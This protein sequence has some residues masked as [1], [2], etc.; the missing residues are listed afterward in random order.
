MKNLD[1]RDKFSGFYDKLIRCIY[2]KY[3][4]LCNKIIPLN[5]D[6]CACTRMDSIRIS[7]N[8]C[9]HCGHNIGFCVCSGQNSIPLPNFTGVYL[10]SGKIRADILNLKFNNEKR[11]AIKLGTEMAERCANVFCDIDFDIITFVPMTKKSLEKRTY[12]QSQLLARQV[13]K[14][15]FVPVEDL[16]EKTRDTRTQFGLTGDER[17]QNL[18]DSVKLKTDIPLKG[19]NI[20][21]CDD[22][23]TTGATLDQCIR[24]LKDCGADKICCI[25]VA[26]SQ[27]S[28]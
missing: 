24:A 15:L 13:G 21:I 27:F 14:L 12:N 4:P 7:D 5:E 17:V 11:L 2:P 28:V 25:T 10:Y 22:V 18:K 23:K 1:I 6:Y 26:V 9:H 3:C 19:K 20:L 16:F 8:H